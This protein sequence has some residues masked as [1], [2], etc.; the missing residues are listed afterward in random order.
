MLQ[1]KPTKS[2][3][4]P[5]DARR[6]SVRLGALVSGFGSHG[7]PCWITQLS[8]EDMRLR[9][10]EPAVLSAK[11][12]KGGRTVVVHL[13]H[14][15]GETW[16]TIQLR[17]TVIGAKGNSFRV[18]LIAP[19]PN[20]IDGLL[21]ALLVQGRA[22]AL[23]GRAA[24]TT[25]PTS[26]PVP[27]AAPTLAPQMRR[28]ASDLSAIA[29]KC[30]EVVQEYGVKWLGSFLDRAEQLLFAHISEEGAQL[31]KHRLDEC[32]LSLLVLRDTLTTEFLNRLTGLVNELF[33]PPQGR[34]DDIPARDMG[35][36]LELIGTVDLNQSL[37]FNEAIDF[38]ERTTAP[39]K[40]VHLEQRMTQ[41]LGERIDERNNPLR[42]DR[43]CVLALGIIC[44]HWYPGASSRQILNDALRDSGSALCAFYDALNAALEVG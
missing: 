19:E 6:Y 15:T 21:R 27:R 25:A 4:Q 26:S 24:E 1:S 33:T 18:R 29:Q 43:V 13:S 8:G 39:A 41:W 44:Q 40:M 11:R 37:A 30:R 5:P 3:N 42:V 34:R 20:V 28:I 16:R 22:K 36:S 31:L 2:E 14:R 32:C 10:A 38:L 9:V 23:S 12:L 7:T 17:A 35:R